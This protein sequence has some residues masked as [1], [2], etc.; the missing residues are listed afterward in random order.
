MSSRKTKGV[1]I[2]YVLLFCTLLGISCTTSQTHA[3]GFTIIGINDVYRIEGVD[4][5]ANG[6]LAR[7]RSLRTEL[8]KANPNVLLLH[9]GDFLF[10]SLLSRQ[11][12][13]KHMIEI[14]NLLDG[15]SKG[16]DDRMF[17]TFGTHE[18]EKD[19]DFLE[20]IDRLLDQNKT[21]A[22]GLMLVEERIR[23]RVYGTHQPQRPEP[24]HEE[25]Q[26]P[27]TPGKRPLP[28]F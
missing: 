16:F 17:V 19:K 6:G 28:R 27:I 12:N 14:L 2:Y 18:F 3:P 26:K 25:T 1:H 13:G 23:E 4:E 22:K 7:V 5:G 10:P 11:Y 21:L 20:K 8:E 15:D 9:G 24:I